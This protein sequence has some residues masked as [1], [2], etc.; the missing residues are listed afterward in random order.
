MH[1]E[2]DETHLY[3]RVADDLERLVDR[4]A[5]KAGERLPS[6][7]RLSKRERVSVSTVLQAYA[8]LESRGVVETRPQSGHYVRRSRLEQLPEPRAPRV[9]ATATR[10]SVQHLVAEVYRA[11]RDPD[12]VPLGAATPSPLL[13]PTERINRALA[14]VAR[15]SGGVGVAYDTPPGCLA[16]RR[17]IAR[18]AVDAGCALTPDE[19]ITTVGAMEALHLSLKAVTQAGDTVVVESPTYYGLLQ[20]IESL[21]LKAVEVP[22]HPRTGLDLD[23]LETTLKQHRVKA[24][25]AIPNFNNPIGSLMPDENKER[26]VAMLGKREIPLIEDDLY[27]DLH[28]GG[29]DAPRPRPAASFDRRGWVLLCASFSKTVAP[30]YRVGWVAPGRFRERVEHLKFAQTVA[31]PTLPQLAIAE[32]LD[33]GGYD[34]HL[35]QLRRR[36]ATQVA[37]FREA[38]AQYFPSGTRVSRPQGGFVLWVELPPGASA[39]TLHARALERGISIAPGPIFSAKQRFAHCVRINC[40]HPWSEVMERSVKTLGRLAAELPSA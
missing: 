17:Q 20:L 9:S 38:V 1:A 16:L 22:Q 28:A 11:A 4:G 26:L 24:V 39:L 14:Q 25:L 5:L 34:H 37:Q 35:R 23:V 19:I 15:T 3:E 13:L 40:G 27:G 10:V 6:V 36:L 12:I 8:L 29:P 32:L 33:S 21:G 2:R 31:T 18:R 7:R 30:G